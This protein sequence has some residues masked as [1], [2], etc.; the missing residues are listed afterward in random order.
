MKYRRLGSVESRSSTLSIYSPVNVQ[1]S[2]YNLYPNE[3]GKFVEQFLLI[4][5]EEFAS[6]EFD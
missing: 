4:Y 1:N 5:S 6:I 2:Y 3:N